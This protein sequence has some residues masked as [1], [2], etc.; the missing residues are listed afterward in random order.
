MKTKIKNQPEDHRTEGADGLGV[1]L[2]NKVKSSCMSRRSF[3]LSGAAAVST[4]VLLPACLAGKGHKVKVVEV[5]YPKKRIAGL[6]GLK[7]GAPIHFSYPSPE[8]GQNFIVKLGVPAGAGVGQGEDIVAFNN[9]C[10]HMGGPVGGS[11]KH[12]HK[13]VGP[14]PFHLTTFDLTRFGI[15]IAGQATESLPQ[16][17]LTVE[18]DDIYATGFRGLLYGRSTNA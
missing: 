10:T 16:V 12:E 3:I 5:A 9:L 18:G 4:F 15:V 17:M 13:A 2:E 6:S 1:A 11:Y 7:E 8:F 14:C